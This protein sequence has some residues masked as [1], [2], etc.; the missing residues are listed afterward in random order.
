LPECRNVGR[1]S[2]SNS[3]F[4]LAGAWPSD[5]LRRAIGEAHRRHTRRV[6]FRDG[7]RGLRPK[8]DPARLVP[9]PS[10]AKRLEVPCKAGWR[11]TWSAATTEHVP[12]VLDGAWDGIRSR[13]STE[14]GVSEA[15]GALEK[16]ITAREKHLPPRSPL[17]EWEYL[18]APLALSP[19]RRLAAD[20]ICP[21]R[22]GNSTKDNRPSCPHLGRAGQARR[23]SYGNHRKPLTT[24]DLRQS[25]AISKNRA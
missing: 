3:R 17:T 18:V 9:P 13:G 24:N 12:A 15:G 25:R 4:R 5:G 10:G 16:W 23:L 20:I 1:G 19:N 2:S 11:V 21:R 7:W 6:N 8:L 22:I 14:Y